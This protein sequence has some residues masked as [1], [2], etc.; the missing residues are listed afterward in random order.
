M[1]VCILYKIAYA[2]HHARIERAL[3]LFILE[4]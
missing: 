2:L 4:N 3:Q 1:Y